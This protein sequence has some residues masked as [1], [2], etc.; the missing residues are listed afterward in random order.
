MS[1]TIRPDTISVSSSS[2]AKPITPLPDVLKPERK[3]VAPRAPRIDV[4]P[5]YSAV[6]GSMGE[7]EWGE[8]KGTLAAFM[9]GMYVHGEAFGYKQEYWYMQP[10]K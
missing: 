2:L 10:R 3:V 5:L 7:S 1:G 4:E 8:Y 9:L 6:K